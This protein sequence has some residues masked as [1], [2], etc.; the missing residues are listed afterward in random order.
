MSK[1]IQMTK[2]NI[3]YWNT[4]FRLIKANLIIIIRHE[5]RITNWKNPKKGKN[6]GRRQKNKKDDELRE[7]PQD[8]ALCKLSK[9]DLKKL[10]LN[11]YYEIILGKSKSKNLD[12]VVKKIK[13]TIS[14]KLT[15]VEIMNVLGIKN[16]PFTINWKIKVIA[17]RKKLNMKR[18]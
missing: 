18:K 13:K 14:N 8:E 12:K 17:K 3:L 9:E 7:K 15:N 16:P 6:V 2:K 11:V 1:Y 10:I 4:A 5:Y